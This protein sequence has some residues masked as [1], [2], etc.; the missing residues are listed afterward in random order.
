MLETFQELRRSRRGKV[1]MKEDES[2]EDLG[3]SWE[4]VSDVK[5]DGHVEAW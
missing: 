4:F 2:L 3:E 5:R 1:L